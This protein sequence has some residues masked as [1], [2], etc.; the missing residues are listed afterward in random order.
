[1]NVSTPARRARRARLTLLAAPL[2]VAVTAAAGPASAGP[3]AGP[4]GRACPSAEFGKFL[5]AFERSVEAQRAFTRWPLPM[6]FLDRE[7]V[8]AQGLP[9]PAEGLL[10]R[11][12]VKSPLF[13]G[14]AARAAAE[15]HVRVEL[16]T[17]DRAKV[18]V[19]GNDG[20]YRVVY[21]F[22]REACWRLVLVDDQST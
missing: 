8:T 15:A 21:V 5:A 4:R 17:P 9:A 2:L 3:A 20:G 10:A 12:D 18:T 1:M 16:L 13:P 22:E 11:G 14:P 6:R 7:Q 19:L